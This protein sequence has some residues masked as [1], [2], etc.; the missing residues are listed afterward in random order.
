MPCRGGQRQQMRLAFGLGD[1]FEI[2]F[3]ELGLLEHRPGDGD[4]VAA[5]QRAY[6]AGW[7]VGDR[8]DAARE[9]G[10]SLGLDLLDQRADDVVEQRDMVAVEAV[11]AVEK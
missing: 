8:R 7:R 4:V 5:G 3:V 6:H 1:M 11:G 10:Q 2:G 9:F